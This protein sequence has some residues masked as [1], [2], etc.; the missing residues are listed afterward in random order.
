M[1]LR[2]NSESN[3][4]CESQYPGP[5][6]AKPGWNSVNHIAALVVACIILFTGGSLFWS[7]LRELI[8]LRA[9]QANL[10]STHHVEPAASGLVA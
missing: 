4:S 7:S 10:E 9:E 3:P 5:N 2:G 8:D 1:S 6:A